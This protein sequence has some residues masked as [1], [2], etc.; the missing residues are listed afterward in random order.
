V[1]GA[2][3][4]LAAMMRNEADPANRYRVRTVLE[5][6]DIQRGDRVLDCGCGLGWLLAVVSSLYECRVE[7]LDVDRD[8]LMRAHREVPPHVRLILGDVTALPFAASS[9]NK[10]ILSEVLEHLADDVAALR[11]VWR[12][13]SPGGVVAITVP[14]RRYPW[15]W[16]PVNR[17]RELM[18]APPIRR[19]FFGG[20][21]TNHQRLY[22]RDELVDLVRRTGF[23]VDDV[24]EFTH[25]CL[26]FAHNLVYGLG[27]ALVESGAL[28]SADRFR[29]AD[30]SGWTPA[31]WAVGL[32]NLVDRL[33]T[34]PAP[35]GLTTVGVSVK[36]RRI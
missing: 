36:A 27:K 1:S 16:D 6:L 30:R 9:F 5:Y 10:V 19:G 12:V 13:T 26:P 28:A 11:E 14:N 33:N 17:L 24:R 15:L 25:Y 21:W 3:A 35:P 34:Y 7:G 2:A 18:G 4:R 31:A 29:Y 8:R 20:I 32:V 22:A 23:V